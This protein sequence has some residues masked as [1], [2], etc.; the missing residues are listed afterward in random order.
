VDTYD[1]LDLARLFKPIRD[2]MAMAFIVCAMFF[3][4][5]LVRVIIWIGRDHAQ[6]VL[7]GLLKN[8]RVGGAS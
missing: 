1:G 5:E 7:E 6:H 2:A 3:H 8:L 4:H